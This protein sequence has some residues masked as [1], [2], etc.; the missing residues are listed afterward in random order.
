VN[1][2]KGP[3][4]PPQN[5]KKMINSSQKNKKSLKQRISSKKDKR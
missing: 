2:R 4:N 1:A 5:V 3:S